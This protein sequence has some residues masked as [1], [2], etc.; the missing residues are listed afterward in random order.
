MVSPVLDLNTK[1]RQRVAQ[2]EGGLTTA[3]QE[4]E[5]IRAIQTGESSETR[6]GFLTVNLRREPRSGSLDLW[7]GWFPV[8]REQ[9]R[10]ARD[11]QI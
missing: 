9:F 8:P 4:I 10:Q 5:Q 6:I 11:R 7:R 3:A 2:L 1:L